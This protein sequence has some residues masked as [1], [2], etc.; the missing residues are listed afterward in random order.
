MA[1][2]ITAGPET[3]T[4]TAPTTTEVARPPVQDHKPK[5]KKSGKK[6]ASAARKAAALGE[7]IVVEIDGQTWTVSSHVLDDFELLEDL[8]AIDS[9][10]PAR[11]PKV[12]RKMLGQE[13]Y[14][15]VMNTLRDE[16]GVVRVEKA[17]DFFYAVMTQAN[18][19]S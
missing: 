10:N 5:A 19:N 12:L 13:Q 11:L 6:K 16:H 18:P 4:E 17:A 2:E 14:A 15:K 7:D 9:G 1:A 8:D 3:E